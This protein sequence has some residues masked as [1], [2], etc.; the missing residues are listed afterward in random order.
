MDLIE[1]IPVLITG[2]FTPAVADRMR[3]KTRILQW[4]ID[5]IFI[6]MNPG[7]WGD[8]SLED[9]LEGRLLDVFPH[10]DGHRTAALNPAENRG[11]FLLQGS[12]TPYA[13]EPTASPPTAFFSLRPEILDDRPRRRP[14]RIPH[15]PTT[16]APVGEQ[17]CLPV[18]ARSSAVSHSGSTLTPGQFGR[19]TGSIP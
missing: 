5:G 8:A 15:P 4:V 6:G 18:R 2:V 3:V 10:P 7:S 9:R 1:A 12:S 14:R 19:W 16:P 11:L 17:R 13:L